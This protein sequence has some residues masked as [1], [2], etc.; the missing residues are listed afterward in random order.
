LYAKDENPVF[1]T[2]SGYLNDD[3]INST[4]TIAIKDGKDKKIFKGTT[5]I[6]KAVESLSQ[7]G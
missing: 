1:A 3:G 7:K 4:P 2:F 6:L 5:D